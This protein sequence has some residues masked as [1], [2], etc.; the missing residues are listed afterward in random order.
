MYI[1]RYWQNINLPDVIDAVCFSKW[2]IIG[3]SG[4]DYFHPD[5]VENGNIIIHI[6]FPKTL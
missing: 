4:R 6:K 3:V 5:I 2:H 1:G